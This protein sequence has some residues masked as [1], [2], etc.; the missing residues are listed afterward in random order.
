MDFLAQCSD[1]RL[2][3]PTNPQAFGEYPF[4]N[5]ELP[6]WIA[7]RQTI[8]VFPAR[9]PIASRFKCR[10]SNTLDQGLAA[11]V[12][13][14]LIHFG[15]EKAPWKTTHALHFSA[16][17]DVLPELLPINRVAHTYEPFKQQLAN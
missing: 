15:L 14:K 16:T 10:K 9:P 6:V 12:L 1:S 4:G 7:H 17:A 3:N 5:F 2:V 13:Q 8:L 11:V